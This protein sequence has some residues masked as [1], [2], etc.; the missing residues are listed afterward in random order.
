MALQQAHIW[1]Q[2]TNDD[3]PVLDRLSDF[4]STSHL[5]VCDA[6]KNKDDET[7]AALVAGLAFILVPLSISSTVITS[8]TMNDKI[9]SN[10]IILMLN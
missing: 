6:T 2:L 3:F 7:G 1:F 4:I 5:W 10:Q 8:Q 9:N